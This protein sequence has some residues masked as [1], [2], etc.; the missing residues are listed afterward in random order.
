MNRYQ[1]LQTIIIFLCGGINKFSNALFKL[2]GFKNFDDTFENLGKLMEEMANDDSKKIKRDEKDKNIKLFNDYIK[3][4]TENNNNHLTQRK[5]Y[6]DMA[7]MFIGATDTTYGALSF[8]MV[9]AAKYPL[10]QEELHKELID[11]FGSKIENITLTKGGILKIPKLRAFIYEVMR[12]YPPAPVA[13]LRD[14]NVIDGLEIDTRPYGGDKIYKVKKG[15]QIM[16][17]TMGVHHNP[18]FWIKDYDPINNDLHKNINMKEIHFEF[19]LD[20][21]GKFDI[22]KNKTNFLTF[23]RGKRDCVGQSLAIKEL[24]IVLAMIFMI[25]KVTGPN[26]DNKFEISTKLGQVIEP[27]PN[28]FKLEIR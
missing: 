2:F 11:A 27:I 12:I 5:L 26:G 8:A 28:S 1:E 19:W 13:G 7:L 4:Y 17:N 23:S 22:K 21:Q 10:I 16:I 6:G 14:I 18:E 15:G 25:Y 3:D 24:Y 9:I 20:S